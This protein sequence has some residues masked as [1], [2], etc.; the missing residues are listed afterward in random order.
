[1][2]FSFLRQQTGDDVVTRVEDA[3]DQ[4]FASREHVIGG[5]AAS[6]SRHWKHPITEKKQTS[7]RSERETPRLTGIRGGKG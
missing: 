7:D 5:G 3:F 4:L 6:L 1:M 2:F